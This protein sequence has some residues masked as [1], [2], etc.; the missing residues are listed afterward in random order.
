MREQ[1]DRSIGGCGGGGGGDLK[2]VFI[3][4]VYTLEVGNV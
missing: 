3:R 2:C 1:S 4:H